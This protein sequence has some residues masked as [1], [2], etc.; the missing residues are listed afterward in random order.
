MKIIAQTN[1]EIF[2]DSDVDLTLNSPV[3]YFRSA[4]TII[5]KYRA[6]SHCANQSMLKRP[7]T[8]DRSLLT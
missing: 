8:F 3:Y 6:V 2:L 4:F 7:Y 1:T 5:Q